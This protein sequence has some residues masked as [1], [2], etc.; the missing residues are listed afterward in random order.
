MGR[1]SRGCPE[2]DAGENLPPELL[3]RPPEARLHS[4]T[5]RGNWRSIA[6]RVGRSWPS[7]LGDHSEERSSSLTE[8]EET[9]PSGRQ[10]RQDHHWAH[11]IDRDICRRTASRVGRSWPSPLG[12]HW[13]E[14]N[15]N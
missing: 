3:D 10:S 9:R 11:K 6:S 13:E 2:Q 12:D 14:R 7:P 4:R 15:S 8:N 1:N 5:G